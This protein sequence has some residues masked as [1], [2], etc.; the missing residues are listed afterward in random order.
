MNIRFLSFALV[1]IL[2]INQYDKV[3]LIKAYYI[4]AMK[5]LGSINSDKKE[6]LFKFADRI[7]ERIT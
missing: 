1:Q 3:D 5:H 2:Q 6:P 7:K 4:K